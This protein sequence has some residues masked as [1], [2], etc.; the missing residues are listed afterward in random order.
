M[1]KVLGQAN[2]LVIIMVAIQPH[3]VAVARCD[4]T[5]R[6]EEVDLTGVVM[7]TMV[8]VTAKIYDNLK[9]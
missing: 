7:V 3:R 6:T 9:R 1:D 5:I 2:I 4:L 8:E